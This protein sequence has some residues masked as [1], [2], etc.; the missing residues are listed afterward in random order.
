MKFAELSVGKVLE[1]L[2]SSSA[3]PG[4]GSAAALAGAMGASLCSMVAGLTLKKE[5]YMDSRKEMESVRRDAQEAIL[6]LCAL[7]DADMKAYKGV[8]EAYKLPKSSETQKKERQRAVQEALKEAARIPME[9]LRAAA[10]MVEVLKVLLERG[11]PNCLTDTGVAA[12]L[13]DSAARGAFYNIRINLSSITDKDFSKQMAEEAEGL[14]E[15]MEREIRDLQ[16][17]LEKRLDSRNC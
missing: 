1:E 13:I 7:A 2:G 12:L 9:T 16:H 15:F 6:E 11:N 5:K 8:M 3:A 14:L 4:G 17:T 10:G